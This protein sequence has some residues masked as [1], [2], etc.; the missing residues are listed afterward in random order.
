MS[1]VDKI[2]KEE[3]QKEDK[4]YKQI[5][6]QEKRKRKGEWD[7]KKD[8]DIPYF[9]PELSYELTGYKP[10]TKDKGLDFRPSWFTEAS[11]TYLRTGHYCTSRGKMYN[12]F[13]RQEYL[14]CINGHTVN[15]YT[16]TGDHYFFLNY[17]QLNNTASSKKAMSAVDKS[18]P[19]FIVAQYI[20]FHYLEM[21]KRLRKNCCLMKARAV[22]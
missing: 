21:C 2:I 13:W 9:D 4:V 20:Y 8:E 10:I 17:Y 14:R 3:K 1:S 18:F 12:D 7:V 5:I 11:Q 16:I 19:N 22:G 15:G 6:E